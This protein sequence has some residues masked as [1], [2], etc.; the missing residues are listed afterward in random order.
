MLKKTFICV[1][2]LA[3]FCLGL[4]SLSIADKHEGPETIVLKTTK[5][6]AKKPRTV[7][8]THRAHQERLKNDC[9]VCH[10]T[11]GDD[12]KQGPY[13]EGQEKKCETCHYK[14]SG[15]A[16]AKV[17]TFKKAAHARCKACHKKAKKENPELKTKWKKC[18]PCHESK[19][20]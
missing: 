12:G 7:N 17:E 20:K 1:S 14:G 6:V 8:F 10:H 3:C 9:S 5:D 4:V 19:K 16:N 18:L 2:V 15:M 11:K 13:V